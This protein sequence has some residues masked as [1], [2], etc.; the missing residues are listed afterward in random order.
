M[1]FMPIPIR[2]GH[3]RPR[4]RAEVNNGVTGRKEFVNSTAR[5]LGMGG[6]FRRCSFAFSTLAYLDW[7]TCDRMFRTVK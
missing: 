6:A 7:H 3:L 4:S 2:A 1:R 5:L